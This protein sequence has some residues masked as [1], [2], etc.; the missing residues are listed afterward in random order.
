LWSCEID[1]NLP[2]PFLAGSKA[3]VTPAIC[4]GYVPTAELCPVYFGFD[5]ETLP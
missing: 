2:T 5:R 1:D 4:N 3:L